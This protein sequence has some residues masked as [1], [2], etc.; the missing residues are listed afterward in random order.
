MVDVIELTPRQRGT[1][2]EID[3]EKRASEFKELFAQCPKYGFNELYFVSSGRN[4]SLFNRNCEKIGVY[5]SG[6]WNPK[7]SRVEYEQVI[8]SSNWKALTQHKKQGHTLAMCKPCRDDHFSLQT[9]FPQG[10]YFEPQ[11]VLTINTDEM[12]QLGKCHATR[13]VFA[14]LNS[15]FSEVFGQDFTDAV[16]KDRNV[17]V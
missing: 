16:A 5:F 13:K 2:K 10:P 11:P 14:E 9:K 12:K 6:R 17:T 7:E 3:K 8:S 15:S 1:N 4:G